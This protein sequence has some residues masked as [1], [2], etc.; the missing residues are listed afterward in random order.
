MTSRQ[1][2]A[3]IAAESDIEY[4]VADEKNAHRRGAERFVLHQR[5]GPR[6]DQRWSGRRPVV[7]E[8]AGS[9]RNRPVA[10]TAPAAINAEQA[11]DISTGSVGIVVADLDTGIRFDHP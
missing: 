3:R 7:P 8:A 10:G 6:S 4:A 5:A 2:A 9:G 1:L 11:W